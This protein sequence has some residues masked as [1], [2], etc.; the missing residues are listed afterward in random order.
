M[1]RYPLSPRPGRWEARLSPFWVKLLRP[2][3]L[4]KQW[5]E[6]R[7]AEIEVRHLDRLATVVH[8]GRGVMITPN[9][10]G[11]ADAYAMYE[12]ADQLRWPFYF[13]SAW[14]VFAAQGVIG[15]W[16]LRVH[17]C[18]SIDRE[19]ADRQAFRT[20]IEILQDKAFPLVVFP[21][22]EVYHQ[23]DRVTPFRE[24]AAAI[25]ITASRKADRPIVCVPCGIKYQYV[26][27][28]MPALLHVMDQLEEKILWRPRRDCD[29]ATRIYRFAEGI[30]S[31]KEIEYL[32]SSSTGPLP[33]RIE[34]LADS[35]LRQLE[36]RYGL[37]PK[38]E[39]ADE[40]AAKAR[41]TIPER[42]KAVRQASLERLNAIEHPEDGTAALEPEALAVEREAIARD[43]DDVFLVVQAFSYPGDYVTEKPTIERLAETLDKFEEDV[44]G[45]KTASIRAARRVIVSFGEPI[46]VNADRSGDG[47]KKKQTP[48]K[49]TAELEQGV[50]TL[51]D[52]IGS[53]ANSRNAADSPA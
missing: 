39:A 52:E 13:M 33:P 15:R 41:A 35:I 2:I 37:G 53:S 40:Q 1:N 31:L 32:G 30:L 48:A 7:V 14:Q 21:E 47:P 44:L 5:N 38:D 25:A 24:G 27:D 28:P 49:L 6:Q 9:H 36:S 10:P 16:S 29:L 43:L 26:E 20:A 42:V 3:R 23:N 17:G 8:E 34:H 51:L 11:H 45:V 18:F 46:E 19:G 22:G 12:A 4:R 50:Q